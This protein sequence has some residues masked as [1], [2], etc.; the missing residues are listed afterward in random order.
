[1]A[2]DSPNI[3]MHSIITFYCCLALHAGVRVLWH[4]PSLGVLASASVLWHSPSLCVLAGVSVLWHSPSLG[5]HAD[6]SVLWQP[7]PWCSCWCQH[8]FCL[9]EGLKVKGLTAAPLKLEIQIFYFLKYITDILTDFGHVFMWILSL[10]LDISPET[11]VT[12]YDTL[13][14]IV[15]NRTAT[16]L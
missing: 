15:S 8:V 16:D 7:K 13:L 1:M 3:N 9:W 6:V 5:V 4:S 12:V 10:I 11:W 14:L 2:E